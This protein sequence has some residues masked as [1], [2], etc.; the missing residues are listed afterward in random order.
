MYLLKIQ[1][2]AVGTSAPPGLRSVV[3]A[4]FLTSAHLLMRQVSSKNTPKCADLLSWLRS[5]SCLLAEND[6]RGKAERSIDVA[7]VTS[8]DLHPSLQSDQ[9]VSAEAQPHSRSLSGI[10]PKDK[11]SCIVIL[12]LLLCV[13]FSW[14]SHPTALS[15]SHA[16]APG[17]TQPCPAGA[18]KQRKS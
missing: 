8:P 5:W 15:V 10:F 9:C 18:Q 6:H 12:L 16:Q 2:E 11:Y 14:T 17:T 4:Q 3:N 1:P 7:P 13:F